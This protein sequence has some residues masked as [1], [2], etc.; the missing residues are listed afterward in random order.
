MMMQG[1]NMTAASSY[2]ASDTGVS[3]DDKPGLDY[4]AL[5]AKL[6]LY[7][8]NGKIQF[9]ADHEAARQYFLQHVNQNTVF[10]HDLEE[11]LEY[12]VEE[13]YYEGGVLERY[14]PEFVKTAF[15]AAYAHRFRFET[16]LG[17]F[18]YGWT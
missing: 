15:K 11:K 2:E 4:H 16:F 7:D 14:S 13:G 17:A 10:F 3:D 18:K 6:N 12:L 1:E 5:N 9:D 8:A